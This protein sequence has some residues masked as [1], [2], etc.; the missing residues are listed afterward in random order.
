MAPDQQDFSGT[1]LRRLLSLEKDFNPID[2]QIE[3]ATIISGLSQVKLN[4]EFFSSVAPPAGINSHARAKWVFRWLLEKLKSEGA[5]RAV[6]K[7]TSAWLLLAQIIDLIRD[8]STAT[9]LNEH[10]FLS[11]VE[12]CLEENFSP[13][14]ALVSKM[15]DIPNAGHVKQSKKRRRDGSSSGTTQDVHII[16]NEER[17]DLLFCVSNVIECVGNLTKSEDENQES[18]YSEHMKAAIR[19]SKEHAAKLLGQWMEALIIVQ[20]D[21]E[22]NKLKKKSYPRFPSLLPM[23]CVWD[24][25]ILPSSG[26][27]DDTPEL[28]SLYCTLPGSKLFPVSSLTESVTEDTSFKD[29]LRTNVKLLRQLFARHLFIPAR[30]SYFATVQGRLSSTPTT[31]TEAERTDLASLLQHI[32][33]EISIFSSTRKGTPMVQDSLLHLVHSLPALLDIGIQRSHRSTPNRKL[34]EAPWVALIFNELCE[35]A[36]L[37][38]S[39][40]DTAIPDDSLGLDRDIK[41]SALELMLETLGRR[42]ASLEIAVLQKMLQV[43]C[44]NI[45]LE[46]Y[47]ESVLVGKI[48]ELDADAI[49]LPIENQLK[50]VGKSLSWT[51]YSDVIFEKLSSLPFPT[52]SSSGDLTRK[53]VTFDILQP[54]SLC[55]DHK[56]AV[57]N[58]KVPM[59]RLAIPMMEAFAR[60]RNL[61]GFLFKCFEEL[62]KHWSSSSGAAS[63]G[64]IWEVEELILPLSKLIRSSLTI[65][66]IDKLLAKFQEYI[67][68]YIL[69]HK[70]KSNSDD[71]NGALIKDALASTVLLN[72]L[73]VSLPDDDTTEQLSARLSI[74]QES[75]E[76]FVLAKLGRKTIAATRTWTSLAYLESH[77]YTWRE[78]SADHATTTIKSKLI[79]LARNCVKETP[80]KDLSYLVHNRCIEAFNYIATKMNNILPT[81][82]SDEAS[83]IGEIINDCLSMFPD[84]LEPT[85]MPPPEHRTVDSVK[86]EILGLDIAWVLNRWIVLLSVIPRQKRLSFFRFMYI[87]AIWTVTDQY[88][89]A[90]G[91]IER[92]YSTVF[93]DICE[94]VFKSSMSTMSSVID[95]LLYIIYAPI[96]TPMK[97]GDTKSVYELFLSGA[98]KTVL[99]V[100]L[101]VIQ[102]KDRE[103]IINT[104]TVHMLS[105]DYVIKPVYEYRLALLIRLMEVPN[106]TASICLDPKFLIRFFKALCFEDEVCSPH[107]FELAVEF[108]R[109]LLEHVVATSDQIR[110]R[111]FLEE[112]I[113]SLDKSSEFREHSANSLPLLAIAS[114]ALLVIKG[115][116]TSIN[117]FSK[118]EDSFASIFERE[119]QIGITRKLANSSPGVGQWLLIL[120]DL[121]TKVRSVMSDDQSSHIQRA[122]ISAYQ[123][124]RD[125]PIFKEVAHRF[126]EMENLD[127]F[128]FEFVSKTLDMESL[129]IDAKAL[130][131]RIEQDLSARSFFKVLDVFEAVIEPL[132]EKEKL[133]VISALLPN[134]NA[135]VVDPSGL[136]LL[137][138]CVKTLDDAPVTLPNS[139]LVSSSLIAQIFN[140]TEARSLHLLL[141]TIIMMLEEK[142]R[143]L[144]QFDYDTLLSAITFI[145]SPKSPK[146]LNSQSSSIFTH[147][148]TLFQTIISLHR[149]RLN[150]RSHL[151]LPPLETLLS[152]LFTPETI[153]QPSW[154]TN[155][156][157]QLTAEDAKAYARILTILCE[158]SVSSATR[159]H[160][161][162]KESLTDET[163]KVR[164]YVGTFIQY[165]LIKSCALTLTANINNAVREALKPGF[166][167]CL[168]CVGA[169]VRRTVHSSLGS[170]E[171]AVWRSLVGEWKKVRGKES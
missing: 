56:N 12:R 67:D 158:P 37:L 119:I 22:V 8:I 139:T 24:L 16:T 103:A 27:I 14:T 21:S 87:R 38:T 29:V 10:G 145:A 105:P 156:T 61:V 13:N 54:V 50:E 47:S 89:P 138:C 26:G 7:S 154:L 148:C 17:I 35:C 143:M 1:S 75:L 64:L 166:W 25:R 11:I 169:D 160:H 15:E 150:S 30:S 147:L 126:A 114:T 48:L 59:N 94:S 115:S 58:H 124:W 153:P 167:A 165:L 144:S 20:G 93:K 3:Q 4:P 70:S 149:Y 33:R 96:I 122:L 32:R 34:K 120:S 85:V 108:G 134:Q 72:A 133:S 68:K 141:D 19:T 53:F 55:Q 132:E 28:F 18:I 44:S 97:D 137:D 162:K 101:E 77:I 111:N 159:G 76:R 123:K 131:D 71:E 95:D 88:V 46:Y 92:T 125:A 121:A 5:G 86:Q 142:P 57:A 31:R 79:R 91:L 65:T 82:S 130:L 110:S 106:A 152:C 90:Q 52:G 41:I 80:N 9:L 84:V 51:R 136:C 66:Q 73:I 99:D 109:L 100:P 81:A 63:G 117:G 98:E 6:R 23:L 127:T 171:A 113:S 2:D 107:M 129:I 168:D 135:K 128:M 112:L 40:Q 62:S 164:A 155:S 118:F 161:S 49:L 163:R 104:L 146:L 36:D 116:E 157:T 42:E 83:S 102:R 170:S 39:G 74:L 151:L 45:D 78:F 43:H 60:S 140:I 69:E